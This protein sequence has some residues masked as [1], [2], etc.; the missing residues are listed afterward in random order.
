VE[1]RA[2]RLQAMGWALG[3]VLVSRLSLEDTQTLTSSPQNWNIFV[4]YCESCSGPRASPSMHVLLLSN[5]S[6]RDISGRLQPI[7]CQREDTAIYA[8]VGAAEMGCE[9][10][11]EMG[12]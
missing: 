1:D 6:D 5:G 11:R 3:R 12:R 8:A 7:C 2:L 9:S 10:E 4:E